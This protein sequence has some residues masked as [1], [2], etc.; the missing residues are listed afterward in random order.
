MKK[1]L[2]NSQFWSKSKAIGLPFFPENRLLYNFLQT[3]IAQLKKYLK[4]PNFGQKVRL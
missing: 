2:K 1:Y 3:A 4:T